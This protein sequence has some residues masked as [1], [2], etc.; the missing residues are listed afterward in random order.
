VGGVGLRPI[1]VNVGLLDRAPR[2]PGRNEM[3]YRIHISEAEATA[4]RLPL[5]REEA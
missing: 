1:V 5:C 2:R 3:C 4:C